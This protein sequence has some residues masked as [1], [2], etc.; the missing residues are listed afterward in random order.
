MFFFKKKKALDK[1]PL[2]K[3]PE[4]KRKVSFCI[5][6][7]NRFEQ[8]SKTLEVNLKD[9]LD[10]RDQIEFI[11][12]DFNDDETIK[13]W[14]FD[15]FK[16]YL[17]DGYLKYFHSPDMPKFHMSAA[18]NA[19]HNMGQGAILV[20]LDCDNYTGKNGGQFVLD[21]FES[22]AQNI[23]L[24][25]FSKIKRDGSHGRISVTRDVYHQLG[26][27]NESFHEMGY[28]DDD[29]M[30]RAMALGAKQVKRKDP[31]YNK[32]I[33]NDKYEPVNMSYEKMRDA[34]K[35]VS[36]KNIKAKQLHANQGKY[37]VNNF[38][39]LNTQGELVKTDKPKV[40][41]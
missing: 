9:N 35:A 10:L 17:E 38:Y 21:N 30:K 14:I 11:L 15:N 26:G 13:N 18:K 22:H 4:I 31:D 34:N 27:Y 23:V 20:S 25:Q 12:T 37:L 5:S 3:D 8:L 28:Q 24:W 29:F 16:S 39:Q 33:P 41:P 36:N 7:K 6:H 1:S 19:C 32:T 2:L 40:N